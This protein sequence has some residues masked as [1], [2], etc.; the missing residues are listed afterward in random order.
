MADD[1]F[2]AALEW[3]GRGFRVF[4][5][6][7]GT[8][9][10]QIEGWTDLATA[11]PDAITRW[12]VDP[13]TGWKR[14]YNI[15]VLTNDMIVVDVDDKNGK[16]GTA[17]LLELDLPLD[18]LIVRTPTGGR[19]VYF[20]GPNKS[21]SVG[22]LGEGLDIR[23]Y[24]GYV[25]A[26]GSVTEAGAY[27]LDN[28]AP[29]AA[30]PAHLIAR[31]DEPKERG[32]SAAAIAELDTPEAIARAVEYAQTCAP[33][34]LGQ[35]ADAYT[36]KVACSVKD[37]GVSQDTAVTILSEFYLPR[38]D[39]A[40]AWDDQVAFLE[41]KVEN[42]Y[43][44][45]LATPGAQSPEADFAGM[46]IIPPVLI[47]N[48]GGAGRQWFHHG[49]EFDP[50]SWLF[51]ELIPTVGVGMM[52]APSSS[53]KTFLTVDLARSLAAGE[54]FF[55][56]EPNERGGTALLLAEGAGGARGRINAIR[57]AGRLPI[58][59]SEIG[60]LNG[61]LHDLTA[62][63]QALSVE[64]LAVYGVPLRL[65]VIDT[66]AA[67]GLLLDEN[68]NVG[69]A[70]AMKALTNVSRL[71]GAF[72]LVVHHPPKDGRGERGAG[73]LRGGADVTLEI[74]RE[75]KSAIR[76]LEIVK[77]R[78]G[79]VGKVGDFTLIPVEIGRDAN[80]RAIETCIVSTAAAP[81]KATSEAPRYVPLFMECLT[82]ALD[83]EGET[84]EGERVVEVEA[85]KEVFTERKDGSRDRSNI[86]KAWKAVLAYALETGAVREIPFGGRRYL[87]PLRVVVNV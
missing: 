83:D 79:P 7:P 25:V 23:S 31:L 9:K 41:R 16:D 29:V 22:K 12:W 13:V 37:M 69:A 66:L 71:T 10:P 53:G 65:V 70:I 48:A 34:V 46:S 75:D 39:A 68:D 2:T 27:T 80:G 81:V 86:S 87:A 52:I 21:L 82:W 73:A 85:V 38:C 64:M 55:G 17:S 45:G 84:I 58:A 30:A 11:D 28:D 15:G 51:H 62:D 57:A 47:G 76:S 35:G 1:M 72:V 43:N 44:Y 49:D 18:T 40:R 67:S 42:A 8:K 36:F 3:A 19:H 77:S 4:P 6:I 26:P 14:N 56:V 24:H 61:K 63:L 20:N 59:A 32:V 60:M 74:R 33:A 78:D 5:L 54:G 50:P